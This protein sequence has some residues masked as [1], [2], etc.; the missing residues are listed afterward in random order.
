[1]PER[2]L[3][4]LTD[5]ILPSTLLE[6]QSAPVRRRAEQA[7]CF[8]CKKKTWHPCRGL[9]NGCHRS[10]AIREL[11]PVLKGNSAQKTPSL[12]T[13]VKL[14]LPLPAEPTDAEPG[15]DAK[16]RVLMARL[17]REEHLW[18]PQDRNCLPVREDYLLSGN[19]VR[20]CRILGRAD[21]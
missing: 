18:H 8:H 4:V 5:L 21:Y 2:G 14:P 10:P 12:G 20:L 17:E 13:R 1:L 6:E 11:Y 9:C 7:V 3:S 15:S 19:G 16:I